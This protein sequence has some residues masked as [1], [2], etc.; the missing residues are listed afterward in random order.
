MPAAAAASANRVEKVA[1]PVYRAVGE[2]AAA[3]RGELSDPLTPVLAVGSAASAVLGSPV[4]AVLV[5]SVLTGN[6]VLAATQQV[7]RRAAVAPAAG[8]AGS[9]RREAP[10]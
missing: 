7:A 9:R 6:A 2:L 1:A 8:G 10:R 3:L 5:G 4:D